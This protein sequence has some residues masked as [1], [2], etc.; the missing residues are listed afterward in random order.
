MGAITIKIPQNTNGSYEITDREAAEKLIRSLKKNS[1]KAKAKTKKKKDFS[2]LSK[3][4]ESYRA[5][6]DPETIKS[7][8]IAEEWRRRW[9]R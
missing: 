3:L 4:M 5:N 6:P 2:A 9:D 8:E 7:I 1:V